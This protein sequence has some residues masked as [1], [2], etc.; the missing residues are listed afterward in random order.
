MIFS[1][2]IFYLKKKHGEKSASWDI[3]ITVLFMKDN[4]ELFIIVLKTLVNVTLVNVTG[5]LLMLP[6]VNMLDKNMV[7]ILLVF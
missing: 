5:P 7:L 6:V 4:H 1:T 3:S 2:T